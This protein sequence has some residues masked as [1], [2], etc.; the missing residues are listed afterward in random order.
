MGTRHLIVVHAGGAYRIAQYGQ[1]DGYPTGQ[2]ASVLKFLHSADLPAFKEKCKQLAFA[3]DKQIEAAWVA[4]GADPGKDLVSME[5]AERL[6]QSNP[7]FSRDT[8]AGI[9]RLVMQADRP[10]LVKDSL[11]FAGD[12]LFCEFGYVIDFDTGMF[13]VYEGFNKEPLSAGDRFFDMPGLEKNGEYE[14]IKLAKSWPLSALPTEEEFL[15]ALEP[16]ET[17]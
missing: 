9:L 1:W 11:S 5:V 17:E 16:A 3:T 10:L 15:A 14:P 7:E 8:G 6:K 2:G 13:E 4:A 12:S